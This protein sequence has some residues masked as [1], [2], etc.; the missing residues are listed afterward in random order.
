MQILYS[1]TK[2]SNT[3]YQL[4][5]ASQSKHV[6]QT[7]SNTYIEYLLDTILHL[8]HHHQLFTTLHKIPVS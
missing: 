6:F 7:V 3:V 1:I 8:H 2:Y 4:K 5:L